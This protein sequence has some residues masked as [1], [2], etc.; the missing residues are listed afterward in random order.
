MGGCLKRLRADASK[1]EKA[2]GT[3]GRVSVAVD[4]QMSVGRSGRMGREKGRGGGW[5]T[6]DQAHPC[7]TNT[8]APE[9]DR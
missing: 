4:E 8:N 2:K 1:E 5:R 3:T 9:L 7:T 6:L